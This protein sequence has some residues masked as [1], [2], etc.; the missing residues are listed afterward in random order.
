MQ[1]FVHFCD[2]NLSAT[3]ALQNVTGNHNT[4]DKGEMKTPHN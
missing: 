4:T 3:A 2:Q 1:N